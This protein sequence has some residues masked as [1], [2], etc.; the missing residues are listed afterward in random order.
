M[1]G[2]AA[3]APA[4]LESLRELVEAGK[5]RAVISRTYSLGEIVEA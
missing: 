1:T 3:P 2:A 5:V 4:D